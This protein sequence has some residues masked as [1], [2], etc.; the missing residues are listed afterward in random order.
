MVPADR[1][2]RRV[3]RVGRPGLPRR[4]VPLRGAGP[5]GRGPRYRPP[6][7]AFQRGTGLAVQ[8]RG[9]LARHPVGPG[10]G[11][12]GLPGRRYGGEADALGRG[13]GEGAGGGGRLD[14]KAA[15]AFEG[16]GPLGLG[17]GVPAQQGG[18]LAAQARD[19]G[20]LGP[21]LLLQLGAQ[22]PGLLEVRLQFGDALLV[23]PLGPGP[24]TGQLGDPLARHPVPAPHE[25]GTDH[26]GEGGGGHEQPQHQRIGEDPGQ[27][28]AGQGER[29]E[30]RRRQQP[31]QRWGMAM[32]ST[33]HGQKL[34]AR[35]RTHGAPPGNLL[36]WYD[37]LPG[38]LPD[39]LPAG[40]SIPARKWPWDMAQ[41][42]S[43]P[44]R[45]TEAELPPRRAERCRGVRRRVFQDHLRTRPH[46]GPDHENPG[47]SSGLRSPAGPSPRGTPRRRRPPSGAPRPPGGSARRGPRW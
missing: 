5:R 39:E 12:L 46:P 42:R 19:L 37:E 9:G 33:W 45:L 29:G 6:R 8:L 16:A 24:R 38:G 20:A 1:S 35:R 47:R 23:A 32:T 17:V 3:L 14:G 40:E 25:D 36:R 18:V 15:A 4:R 43:V 21:D 7:E 26:G 30:D 10:R 2:V 22:F 27:C 34:T 44:A 13:G 41:G 28:G 31:V 11:H